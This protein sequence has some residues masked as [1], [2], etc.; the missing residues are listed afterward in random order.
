MSPFTEKNF[1]Q[2]VLSVSRSFSK[3]T[4]CSASTWYT[5]IAENIDNAAKNTNEMFDK[6]KKKIQKLY[7]NK[8]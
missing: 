6:I 3:K 1:T 4:K 5:Y 2:C 8:H 7:Q